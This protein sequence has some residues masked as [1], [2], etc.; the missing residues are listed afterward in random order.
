ME[1]I[2]RGSN[3]TL[4]DWTVLMITFM[5]TYEIRMNSQV[6]LIALIFFQNRSKYSTVKLNKDVLIDESISISII[7]LFGIL[8]ID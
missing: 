4:T 8:G 5:I 7:F 3:R 6:T 2:L 1:P